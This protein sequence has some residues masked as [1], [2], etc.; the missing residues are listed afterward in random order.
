MY[1]QQVSVLPWAYIS[2]NVLRSRKGFYSKLLGRRSWLSQFEFRQE[3]SG[4]TIYNSRSAGP[5][6]QL[7]GDIVLQLLIPSQWAW[8]ESRCRSWWFAIARYEFREFQSTAVLIYSGSEVS[9]IFV[10][11]NGRPGPHWRS[12]WRWRWATPGAA[13]RTSPRTSSAPPYCFQP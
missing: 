1:Q 10:G 11:Q 5:G 3:P 9:R 6:H 13:E 2:L 4:L 7:L 12:R 8:L